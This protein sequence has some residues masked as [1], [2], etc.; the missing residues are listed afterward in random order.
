MFWPSTPFSR[1]REFFCSNGVTQ[2]HAGRHALQRRA[3]LARTLMFSRVANTAGQ[4]SRLRPIANKLSRATE[5][6]G[7]QT[8][9]VA[10]LVSTVARYG[11]FTQEFE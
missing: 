7:K 3:V 11:C 1:R 9:L 2:P 6:V 8:S 10:R 4:I 5:N